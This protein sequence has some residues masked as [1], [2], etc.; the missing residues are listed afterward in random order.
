MFR[1]ALS[2]VTLFLLWIPVE[3]LAFS[4]APSYVP[5]LGYLSHQDPY[6]Q[7]YDNTGQSSPYALQ[8]RSYRAAAPVRNTQDAWTVF[9]GR[10][11]CGFR[12]DYHVPKCY[13][14]DDCTYDELYGG[15]YWQDYCPFYYKRSDV[16]YKPQAEYRRVPLT[17]GPA[18]RSR[19]FMWNT[20]NKEEY[21]SSYNHY[22]SYRGSDGY[23]E[24][25]RYEWSD[26]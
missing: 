22:D 2:V 25:N 16:R 11:H 24:E 23:R 6:V 17:K 18:H 9:K 26:Y 5:G 10:R 12:P 3:V 19:P 13:V 14:Y 20:R 8:N 15:G 1:F 21:Q 7:V 4:S